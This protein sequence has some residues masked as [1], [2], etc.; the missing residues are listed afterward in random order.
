MNQIESTNFFKYVYN[1]I[2]F[3]FFVFF[4]IILWSC[5]NFNVT[6]KGYSMFIEFKNAS[7]IREGTNL[8]MRGINIGYVKKIK[9]DLN[10]IIILAY[11]QSQDILIPKKTI[12]ETNQTGILNETVID[13][14]P[15]DVIDYTKK[16]NVLSKECYNSNIICHLNYV[17]G[18]RGL[19]YDDLVRAVT[20]ISQRFDDPSFFKIFYLFLK[21]GIDISD[22]LFQITW[23]MSNTFF[24]FCNVLKKFLVNYS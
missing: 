23:N 13:I 11:I 14:M 22:D 21:N 16:I 4:T 15:L 17:Q 7:G 1:I 8:R 5:I 19:N 12:I 10:S 2:V 9:I 18:V 20:R 3:C 6:T 24:M